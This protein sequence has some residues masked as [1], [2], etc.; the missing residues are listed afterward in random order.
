[1]ASLE[2][3]LFDAIDLGPGRVNTPREGAVED[4][5]ALAFG[6]GGVLGLPAPLAGV[7]DP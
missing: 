7:G 2:A 6:M 1:M 3:A 4:H 5:H